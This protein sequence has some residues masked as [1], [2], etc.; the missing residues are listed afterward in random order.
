M[1]VDRSFQKPVYVAQNFS[2]PLSEYLWKAY[3]SW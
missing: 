3:R 1:N 2:L